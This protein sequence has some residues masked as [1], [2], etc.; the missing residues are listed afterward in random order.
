MAAMIQ[1]FLMG[2]KFLQNSFS[3]FIQLLV[4]LQH[5]GFQPVTDNFFCH[6]DRIVTFTEQ[7]RG[8]F[9]KNWNPDLCGG[10]IVFECLGCLFKFIT[11]PMGGRTAY[12]WVDRSDAGMSSHENL[13]TGERNH[14]A[15]GHRNL[16][17]KCT[18]ISIKGMSEV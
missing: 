15:S 7:R 5:P 8:I 2:T 12:L 4:P 17:H 3:L 1:T 9:L 16:R 6:F 11:N 10:G 13:V 18:H 14:S